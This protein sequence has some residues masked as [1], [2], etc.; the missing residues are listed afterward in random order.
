MS[1]FK[2]RGCFRTGCF[3]FLLLPLLLLI[4]VSVRILLSR[5]LPDRF[6]LVVPLTGTLEERHTKSEIFTYGNSRAPLSL[7]ELLLMLDQ[8]ATDERVSDVVLDL[9]GFNASSAK[10]AELRDAITNLRK[11]GKKSIAFLRDGD[12]GQYLLATACDTIMVP[13][14]GFLQLDGLRAEL[15]FFSE[16]LGNIGID[17]QAAQWKE[18]KSGVEPF[19]RNSA[20]KAYLEQVNTLLDDLYETYVATV[21]A[22]RH[23]TRSSFESVIDNEALLSADRAVSLGIADRIGSLWELQGELTR[24]LTGKALSGDND[25][26]VSAETYLDDIDLAGQSKGKDAVAVLTLSGPILRSSEGVSD[27]TGVVAFRQALDEALENKRAKAIV[28]RIDS[29]GGDAMASGDILQM[30]DSAA[31]KKPLVVSMSGV[32]ASGGYM[33]ALAGKPLYAHPETI[34]GSIGVYALKPNISSLANRIGLHREVVSRGRF[35]DATT[36]FKPLD[37]ESFQKFTDASGLVYNDFLEKVAKSRGMTTA[38]VDAVAGGRIWSGKRALQAGLVDRTGSF[39]DAIAEAERRAG[40][41]PEKGRNGQHR[42]RHLLFYPAE[43]SWTALLFGS[44]RETLVRTVTR[45][46]TPLQQLGQLVGIPPAAL[47][48]TRE[49]QQMGTLA[50]LLA[51]CGPAPILTLLPGD[52][53][54]R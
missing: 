44:G 52:I 31:V 41:K 1:F 51:Q 43:K 5:S 47:P 49:L 32:A 50:A 14:G 2:K 42:A 24:K 26:F 30:L 23:L 36:I 35:A 34:T 18:Y 6:A 9:G 54:I 7:Q 45:A 38:Q 15:L 4:G 46:G 40:I 53:I 28:L 17:M 16:T 48:V 11:N 12:D 10:M 21:V 37:K 27:G 33:A 13:R 39:F 25:A 19:L 29:P 20:S 8:A 22:R 3:L